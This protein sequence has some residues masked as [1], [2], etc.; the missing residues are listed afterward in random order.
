[1][2]TENRQLYR[3][4]IVRMVLCV[5][6]VIILAGFVRTLLASASSNDKAI[7]TPTPGKVS[8]AALTAT[9]ATTPIAST[10]ARIATATTNPNATPTP[11]PKVTPTVVPAAPMTGGGSTMLLGTNLNL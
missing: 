2:G 7:L 4:K 11:A 5:V 9:A 6:L 8:S 3:N 1:M 10:K